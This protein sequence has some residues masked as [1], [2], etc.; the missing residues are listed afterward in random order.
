[1][2]SAKSESLNSSWPIWMP[3]ISLC[4][5]IAEARTSNTMLNNSGESGHA[6]HVPDLKGKALSFSPLWI[7]LL[8]GLSYMAFVIFEVWSFYP[9]FLE[10]FYQDRML[11]FA[12]CFLCIY[13]GSMWFLSFPLL[14]WCITL[15][16]L[17]I[18][19]QPCIP[20]INP[21]WSWWIILLMYCWIRLANILWRIFVSILIREICLQ[22]YFLVESLV[23]ESR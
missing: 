17:Q 15:I 23:L 22:F 4:C 7:I 8:V 21:T 16:V 11:Y 14:I 13:W 19:N 2:S 3:F 12:K 10:G 6:C 18:L 9:Y 5:L 1:M 20:G